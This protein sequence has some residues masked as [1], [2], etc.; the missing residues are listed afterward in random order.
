MISFFRASPPTARRVARSI[1]TG[2]V[3]TTMRGDDAQRDVIVYEGVG[4]VEQIDQHEDA[5]EQT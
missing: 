1:A 4:V 3:R 5:R 2:D